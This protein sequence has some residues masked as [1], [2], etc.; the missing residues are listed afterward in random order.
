M[1]TSTSAERSAGPGPFSPAAT[2]LLEALDGA[3]G[4]AVYLADIDGRVIYA[5]G[6]ADTETPPDARIQD[7]IK[8]IGPHGSYTLKPV[9]GRN[10]A[11]NGTLLVVRNLKEK[12]YPAS[13]DSR[14]STAFR[15]SPEGIA[16]LTLREGIFIEANRSFLQFAGY[17]RDEIL[18][19][20]ALELNIGPEKEVRRKIHRRLTANRTIHRFEVEIPDRRGIIHNCLLSAGV[21]NVDNRTCMLMVINDITELKEIEKALRVSEE[22][23]YKAFHASP[24]PISLTTLHD[25]RYIEVNESYCRQIGYRP[26]ELIG[27]YSH[28]VNLFPDR[29]ERRLMTERLATNGRLRNQPVNYYSRVLGP[30][31]ARVSAEIIDL[32]GV[33]C[34]LAVALD[35]TEELRLEKEILHISE[36]ERFRVGQDLHD[37]LGQHLIGIEAMS[38]LLANRLKQKLPEESAIADDMT[39]LIREA[40][41]KTRRMARGLCPV[42]LDE[43]GLI[44][45][46]A[47][48][49]KQARALF[50]ISC[51]VRH[52]AGFIIQN[53]T[54]ATH[55][56]HIAQESVNNAIR[57]GKASSINVELYSDAD[58]VVMTVTDDGAGFDLPAASGSG[59]GL[60]IMK[61]RSEMIG[62]TLDIT[63][64]PGAGTKVALQLPVINI[65][66]MN[67]KAE[68]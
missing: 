55:L 8:K 63:S 47:D 24:I 41:V 9:P 35:N 66:M 43:T 11:A 27:R 1:D 4:E 12:L 2:S 51:E 15:L 56:Y 36:R 57:H 25:G 13:G 50:G 67:R 38:A 7:I 58:L 26:E 18:G 30:R 23:Y 59:M 64:G 17:S 5:C 19:K 6:A 29:E 65:T 16:I 20:S 68:L 34:M 37:D 54:V 53:N 52:N 28:E 44:T 22:K 42:S 14:Y 48:L 32:Q 10:G 3:I 40:T 60:S 33:P 62:A 61:Y 49:A 45:A 46:L 21:I 39:A 31:T